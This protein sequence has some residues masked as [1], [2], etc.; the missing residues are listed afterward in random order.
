[1]YQTLHLLNDMEFLQKFRLN[2]LKYLAVNSPGLIVY[3]ADE[4]PSIEEVRSNKI[5]KN[6]YE[7]INLVDDKPIG[8]NSQK[9]IVLEKASLGP[10]THKANAYLQFSQY[11]VSKNWHQGGVNNLAILG[12]VNGKLN[13]DNKKG[14]QWENFAEWRA[15][16]N[17]IEGDTMRVLN[18]NDDIFRV[19]SKL[20]IK[21]GGDFFYSGAFDFSMPVFP[22]YKAVNST[23]L[24][25]DFMTPVR[26]NLSVGLDYK[27]KKMF[28]I[29]VSPIAYKYIYLNNPKVDPKL[30]GIKAGENKL[31]EIG[32]SFRFQGNYAP[33][34]EITF[35]TRLSFYTNYTKVEV[36]WEIIGNFQVNRFLSTRIILNPRYDSTQILA[37]GEK[38]K[39][40]F[41]ELLTFGLSYR[42]LD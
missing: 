40:Q 32:S 10:W 18:T 9:K 20:G 17:S 31:K 12:T 26:M 21:A 23:F 6:Y 24:K 33:T 39:V 7:K 4:L 5:N 14:I 34:K 3:S 41:K 38:A 42:L 37:A 15:G 8:L 36:D 35:D 11:Y 2:T 1:M 25:A 13:Y 29:M 19:N 30:F 22:T 27:Y 28:S 16:F